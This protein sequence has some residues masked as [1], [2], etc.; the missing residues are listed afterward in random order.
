MSI[1]LFIHFWAFGTFVISS[2]FRS[3]LFAVLSCTKEGNSSCSVESHG[4]ES[5]LAVA[6]KPRKNLAFPLAPKRQAAS[7]TRQE[8]SSRELQKSRRNRQLDGTEA[9]SI[10]ENSLRVRIKQG[11]KRQ[12]QH[13]LLQNATNTYSSLLLFSNDSSFKVYHALWSKPIHR[14]KKSSSCDHLYHPKGTLLFFVTLKS[15]LCKRQS[16]LESRLPGHGAP[17]MAS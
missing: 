14:Q 5:D 9:A 8:L 16:V 1:H 10:L 3:H 6:N 11:V 17:N 15:C 12:K 4:E 13:Q 7:Q 2:P